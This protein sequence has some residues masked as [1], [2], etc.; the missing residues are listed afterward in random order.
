MLHVFNSTFGNLET[1]NRISVST[2][3]SGAICRRTI[4]SQPGT[5]TKSPLDTLLEELCKP[6]CGDNCDASSIVTPIGTS[7]SAE[8]KETTLVTGQ[9]TLPFQPWHRFCQILQ[10][11]KWRV[12]TQSVF[13]SLYVMGIRKHRR[14]IFDINNISILKQGCS[15]RTSAKL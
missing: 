4:D 1:L 6:R 7:E 10:S 5:T 8:L 13:N 9:S 2:D 14:R 15:F 3:V 12:W 11:H